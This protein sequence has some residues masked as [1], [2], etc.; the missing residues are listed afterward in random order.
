[1]SD[2]KNGA[3]NAAPDSAQAEKE[4]QTGIELAKALED[5]LALTKAN[6]DLKKELIDA[7][8]IVAELKAK[9]QDGGSKE[10]T[11]T[12]DKKVYLVTKG[13]RDRYKVWTPVDIAANPAKAKELIQK[14]STILKLKKK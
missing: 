6:E 7:A 8:K 1:M 14:D 4:T 13:F 12:I 5:N 11:I 10:V 2:E 9:L 3:A